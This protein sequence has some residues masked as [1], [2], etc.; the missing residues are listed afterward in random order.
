MEI[1]FMF[2]KYNA[3]SLKEMS[4]Q[5]TEQVIREIEGLGGKVNA[6]HA[7]LG[8]YDLLFC[9]N[10]PGL[11]AAMKASVLLTKATGISFTTYP[12]ITVEAFDKM[13]A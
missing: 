12:A 9:V 7:L 10:L 6:M 1:F 5:R 3:Q 4:Y 13:I 11:D 2:G 8:K